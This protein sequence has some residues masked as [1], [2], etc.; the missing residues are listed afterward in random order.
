[1]KITAI[2]AVLALMALSR[3]ANA[4][5]TAREGL[6][7]IKSNLENSKQNLSGYRQNLQTVD[8]NVKEVVKARQQLETQKG[9]VA[10]AAQEN[11]QQLSTYTRQEGE[12]QLLIK[13]EQNK[14][15]QEQAKIEELTRLV[16]QLKENQKKREANIQAYKGQL[17][18]ATLEKQEWQSRG[19]KI[20][21]ASTE[22]Q[23]RNQS[24][25][26]QETEWRGKRKGYEG[27]VTRWQKE[28]DRNQKLQDTYS[29]LAEVKE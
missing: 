11:S 22:L 25:A 23:N 29:S 6:G 19:E 28:V 4:Q 15:T 1:M 24:L 7:Q 9:A 18:Q 12:V 10:K 13:E 17:N 3:V 8:G 27:E 20:N 16:N 5:M 2:L 26:N 21:K 14:I